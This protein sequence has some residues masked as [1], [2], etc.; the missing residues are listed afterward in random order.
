MSFV[1]RIIGQI[2]TFSWFR[3]TRNAK[4]MPTTTKKWYSSQFRDDKEQH[5]IREIMKR[6]FA[7]QK[8]KGKHNRK[9]H[10][11]ILIESIR[12]MK[13][14]LG[15]ILS[16]FEWHLEWRWLQINLEM[17][18]INPWWIYLLDSRLKQYLATDGTRKV[19]SIELMPSQKARG[20]IL[21]ER[22]V[23]WFQFCLSMTDFHL[24]SS[25]YWK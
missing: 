24:K 13:H 6:A 25:S 12:V 22:L 9:A 3:D 1:V 17:D 5:Q 8:E 14:S 11:H 10:R 2:E 19:L 16:Y 20:L 21:T 7:A 15:R 18:V 4:P 23:S